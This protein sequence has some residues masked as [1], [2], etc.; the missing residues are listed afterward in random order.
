[1]NECQRTTINIRDAGDMRNSKF[2]TFT[3]NYSDLI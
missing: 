1:M 2:F 3:Q